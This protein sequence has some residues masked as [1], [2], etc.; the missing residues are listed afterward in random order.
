M[1]VVLSHV[2][3][4]ESRDDIGRENVEIGSCSSL[5]ILSRSKYKQ[6]IDDGLLLFWVRITWSFGEREKAHRVSNV[7]VISVTS[8]MPPLSEHDGVEKRMPSRERWR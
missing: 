3:S 2:K 8:R 6:E 4:N 5:F 7:D 1:I